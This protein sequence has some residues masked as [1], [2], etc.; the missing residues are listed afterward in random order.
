[1]NGYSLEEVSA[2]PR[3]SKDQLTDFIVQVYDTVRE[4][5]KSTSMEDLIEPGV[6]FSGK[7]T[8]Y[9]I[10]SMALLD[11]VRHLGEIRLIKSL[12]E[13]SPSLNNA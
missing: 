10:I 4:Y 9:Q 3:F 12:W 6:G 1:L 11:N 8:R 2:I 7:Y 5:L 13:R